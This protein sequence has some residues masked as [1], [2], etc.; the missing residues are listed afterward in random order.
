MATGLSALPSFEIWEIKGNEVTYPGWASVLLALFCL[1][2]IPTV[3]NIRPRKETADSDVLAG[4]DSDASLN[5]PH[6][7]P[8]SEDEHLLVLVPEFEGTKR[9]RSEMTYRIEE[10]TGETFAMDAFSVYSPAD[11]HL[12]GPSKDG[13]KVYSAKGALDISSAQPRAVNQI[14]LP[15]QHSGAFDPHSLCPTR[16]NGG[17]RFRTG[18]ALKT[19][20]DMALPIWT[21]IVVL[22]LQ[23]AFYNAFT[24]FET[25]G[26]TAINE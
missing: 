18:K 10:D 23:F 3:K 25:I 26:T 4:D 2:F 14:N 11:S 20:K 12:I 24:V 22:Y 16:A 19:A 8:I 17:F 21:V 15:A 13:E 1:V 9:E 7:N 6:L 5:H